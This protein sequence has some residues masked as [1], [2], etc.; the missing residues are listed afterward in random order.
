MKRRILWSVIFI[1]MLASCVELSSVLLERSERRAATWNG[2]VRDFHQ[3]TAEV[4]EQDVRDRVPLGSPRAFVEGFLTGEGMKFSFDP[5]SRTILANAPYL[6][7]SGFLVYLSLDFKFQFD[8]AST[9]RAIES[10]VH[11]TGP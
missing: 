5:S 2:A 7:G 8:D 4:L 3:V 11:R 10:T 1:A 9:L 6:K